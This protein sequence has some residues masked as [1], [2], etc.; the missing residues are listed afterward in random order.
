[1]VTFPAMGALEYCVNLAGHS[2]RN[3]LELSA[4]AIDGRYRKIQEQ[5]EQIEQLLIKHGVKAIPCKSAEI[6][7]DL[8]ATDDPLHSR[9]QGAYFHGYEAVLTPFCPLRPRPYVFRLDLTNISRKAFIFIGAVRGAL[10]S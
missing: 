4:E 1:M 2:T 5:A 9:Q 6:V 10:W 3:R 7:L 8:D